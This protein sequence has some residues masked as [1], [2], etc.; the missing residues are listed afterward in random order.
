MVL[1]GV[2]LN[3]HDIV[4]VFWVVKMLNFLVSEHELVL[5]CWAVIMNYLDI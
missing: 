4:L 1:Y 2:F 5:V 3:E